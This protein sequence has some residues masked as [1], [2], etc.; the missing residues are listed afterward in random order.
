M[1]AILHVPGC[2]WQ[3]ELSDDLLPCRS[4][5]DLVMLRDLPED[6]VAPFTGL[7]DIPGFER[8]AEPLRG[9]I[10]LVNGEVTPPDPSVVP[11]V[12]VGVVLIDSKRQLGFP[13]HAFLCLV[14]GFK[15]RNFGEED[16][17]R[18]TDDT[19]WSGLSMACKDIC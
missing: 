11:K 18:D 4:G 16:A 8:K 15:K 6:P 14:T 7:V 2:L 12:V 17:F 13:F 5:S 19:D 1:G 10:G 9:R 3:P